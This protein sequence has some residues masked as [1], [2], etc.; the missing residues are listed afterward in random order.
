MPTRP[1]MSTVLT[2]R[3]GA[4]HADLWLTPTATPWTTQVQ[5]RTNCDQ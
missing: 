4:E 2:G 5:F 3:T 1:W